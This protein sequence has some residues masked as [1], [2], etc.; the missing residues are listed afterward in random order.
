M[1]CGERVPVGVARAPH[2]RSTNQVIVFLDDCVYDRI[3]ADTKKTERKTRKA[4]E[5]L[6]HDKGEHAPALVNRGSK[7]FRS[8]MVALK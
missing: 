6:W 8:L 1:S 7:P 3:D 4:G 5:V 2:I